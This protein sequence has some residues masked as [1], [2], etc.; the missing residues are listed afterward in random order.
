MLA[1]GAANGQTGA[2]LIAKLCGIGVFVLTV[3]TAHSALGIG[4]MPRTKLNGYSLLD[5]K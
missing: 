4:N 5:S 2:A 3:G 1:V